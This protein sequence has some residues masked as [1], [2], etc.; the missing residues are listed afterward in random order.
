MVDLSDKSDSTKM[1]S[2]ENMMNQI[3]TSLVES[4]LIGDVSIHELEYEIREK[5]M[6]KI[7][8]EGLN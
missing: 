1:S 8:M 4:I 5:Y 3:T 2:I 6:C 7:N